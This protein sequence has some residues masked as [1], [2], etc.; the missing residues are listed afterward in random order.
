MNGGKGPDILGVCEVENRHVLEQ[1]I[2]KLN[3]SQRSYNISHEEMQDGRGIDVAFIY[4]K[5]KFEAKEIFSHWIVKRNS[6]RDLFQVNFVSK[7]A[8]NDLVLIG[9][10]WPAR[11]AGLYKSEPYRILAAET[12]SYWIERIQEI[13]GTK[14]PILVTGDF[15]D[16]PFN[17]SL[18]EYTLSSNSEATVKKGTNPWLFN[19][20]WISLANGKASYVYNGDLNMLDQCMVSKGFLQKQS[21]FKLKEKF[22]KVEMF[23]DMTNKKEKPIK[24]G[25]KSKKNLNEKGYSDHFP[26]SLMVTEE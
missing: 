21:T 19:L 14:I 20:M 1:L 13:K 9:N 2:E 6:T 23:A 22:A 5:N 17:R 7:E 10:H 24:F 4:D 3:I 15:N 25:R 16:E 26:I 8:G 11:T 18:M 12:L